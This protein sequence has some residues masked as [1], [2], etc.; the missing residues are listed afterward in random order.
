MRAKIAVEAT[1]N[2][3][4]AVLTSAVKRPLRRELEAAGF[5]KDFNNPHQL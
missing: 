3:S 1:M 5:I 2:T 4:T